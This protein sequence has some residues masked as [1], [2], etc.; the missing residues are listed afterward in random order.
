MN[1]PTAWSRIDLP[2]R[3][4]ASARWTGEAV[5]AAEFAEDN[6]HAVST[7]HPRRAYRDPAALA[8]TFGRNAAR[9]AREAGASD[10]YRTLVLRACVENVLRERHDG[11]GELRIDFGAWYSDGRVEA[12][13]WASPEG[14]EH[15]HGKSVGYGATDVE[16]LENLA[17][18][19]GAAK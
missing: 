18:H 14:G 12:E 8:R 13:A 19:I 7:V 5:E 3:H 16:A 1:T 15:S 10:G 6:P 11:A 9:I 2:R 4:H 17:R